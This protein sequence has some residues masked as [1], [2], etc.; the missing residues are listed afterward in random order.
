V[1]DTVAALGASWPRLLVLGIILM[2]AIWTLFALLWWVVLFFW[3]T[4]TYVGWMRTGILIA[5]VSSAFLYLLKPVR[6]ARFLSDPSW[7][8]LPIRAWKMK[9][10]DSYLNPR[11]S[12]A[13]HALSIDENRENFARV[14]WTDKT[15]P[16]M[17]K[18][19]N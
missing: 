15:S 16:R 12:Y 19:K 11:V 14:P 5:L 8:K 6:F 7:K 1:W 4:I 17:Q 18:A 9:F 13:K 2:L 10:Y 3:P